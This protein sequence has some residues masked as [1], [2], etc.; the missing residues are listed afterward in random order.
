[1]TTKRKE[2]LNHIRRIR[3]QLDVIESKLDS[4]AVVVAGDAYTGELFNDLESTR[5]ELKGWIE[6]F[7]AEGI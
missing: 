4:A 7:N 5:T 3:A 1:M 6:M 2:C